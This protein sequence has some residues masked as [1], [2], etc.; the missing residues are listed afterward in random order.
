MSVDRR[1]LN[2]GLATSLDEAANAKPTCTATEAEIDKAVEGRHIKWVPK[3]EKD[4][5]TLNPEAVSVGFGAVGPKASL[6]SLRRPLVQAQD[7][8]DRSAVFQEGVASVG[9]LPVEVEEVATPSTPGNLELHEGVKWVVEARQLWK[10]FPK[11]TEA[12]A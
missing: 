9:R 10:P 4:G 11:N 2:F 7:M 6:G 3:P 12:L 8:I 5:G 1:Q